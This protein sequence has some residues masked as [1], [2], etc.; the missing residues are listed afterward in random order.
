[1][2]PSF[3]IVVVWFLALTLVGCG[4]GGG[5]VEPVPDRDVQVTA[6]STDQELLLSGYWPWPM[7]KSV[8]TVSSAEQW[9]QVWIERK[10]LC[11]TPVYTDNNPACEVQL[12][13]EV[14]FSQY[15]V[16]GVVAPCFYGSTSSIRAYVKGDSGQTVV[17]YKYFC[18]YKVPFNPQPLFSAFF[19]I[20]KASGEIDVR[21]SGD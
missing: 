18:V 19:L 4:G 20:P 12:P 1:M 21:V 5:S 2:S 16:V 17:E 13:P 3:S 6:F 15:A 10:N 9:Q 7:P 14:D 8:Y 11:D